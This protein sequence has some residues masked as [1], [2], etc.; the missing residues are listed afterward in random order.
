MDF[1]KHADLAS[2]DPQEW[3]A[4]VAEAIS[5]VPFLRHEYLQAWWAGRGGG[6]W[7]Q[8]ELALISARQ[9]GKLVG[10]A[11]LFAAE[12]EGRRVLLL[13]GSIE[14]SDYLDLIVRQ[15]DLEA[16]LAGLMDFLATDPSLAGW[17]GL[18]WYNLPEGSP[19]LPALRAW[20]ERGG[21]SYAEEVY[22]P[23]PAIV[24][25]GSFEVY[26]ATVEKK[27]RHEIRRKV[28]RAQESGRGV[29]WYRVTERPA[30][31][32]EMEG[33][34][35]LMEDDPRKAEFL[36]PAM[37]EQ[38]R[39]IAQA[40][41]ENGWLWLAFLEIDGQK[42]AAA[43]NFDYRG[44]LWGYNSGVDRRFMELSPG[45]VLLAYILQWAADNGRSEFDFMRGGEE[46]KYRFGAV[47]RH[48][49]RVQVARGKGGLRIKEEVSEGG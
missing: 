22:R 20:A 24:L 33:L 27:Q 35:H 48:V 38:M 4:L 8:A 19:T 7:P 1:Q 16:F 30:L 36:E 28:R 12:H 44:R 26:L 31:E 40:A 29:R 6:E 46:Y 11:P 9:D 41:L 2:I 49:M 47:D 37:R 15:A 32:A 17:Q 13:L 23:T 34:F 5:D 43:F 10:L 18:D 45:W 3:N 39:S 42:A 14:I 25:P 21:W